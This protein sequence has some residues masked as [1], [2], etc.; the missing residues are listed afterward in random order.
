MTMQAH[1]TLAEATER[2]CLRCEH[3]T[4]KRTSTVMA[5]GPGGSVTYQREYEE[6]E[7]SCK[8][9][10]RPL[11]SDGGDCPYWSARKAVDA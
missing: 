5:C 1:E 9:R 2:L 4:T 7:P 11:T 6:E 8:A 3:W 10:L